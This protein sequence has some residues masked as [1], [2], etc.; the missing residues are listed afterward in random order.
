MTSVLALARRVLTA[1]ERL[2]DRPLGAVVLFGCALAY[3]RPAVAIA[4]PLITGRDLDEYLSYYAQLRLHDPPLPAIMINHTP[5]TPLFDGSVLDVAGGRLAEPLLALCF[6]IS[7]TAWGVVAE[8]FGSRRRWS[9]PSILLVYPAFGALFH[10]LSSEAVFATTF[11]LWSLLLVRAIAQP[12]IG[13]FATVGAGVAVLTLVRPGNQI[14][15][16]SRST[17]WRFEDQQAH[18]SRGPPPSSSPLHSARSLG[19][20]ERRALR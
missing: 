3:R 2:A 20:R 13:R 15:V 17:R 12:S 18:G 19:G 14:L 10:E 4:W 8:S 9:L 16:P 1:L 7:I 6:A 5:L 11:A